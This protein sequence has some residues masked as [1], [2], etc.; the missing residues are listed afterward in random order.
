MARKQA[1]A[2]ERLYAVD[3]E[4][5]IAERKVLERELRDRGDTEAAAD[6]AGRRKPMLPVFAANRLARARAADVGKLIDAAQ[7]IAAA[8]E[9]GDRERLRE[10]QADLAERVRELLRHAEQ[11]AGRPL[12]DAAEQ[13]LASLLRA[14]AVDPDAAELLRRGVLAEELEPAG[15][16]ALAGLSLA[17]APKRAASSGQADARARRQ[18]ERDA[19]VAELER[20][21]ADARGALRDAEK[22]LTAAERQADRARRRVAELEERLKRDSR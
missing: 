17:P 15:F 2:L 16:E 13:R 19:K 4:D 7:R 5:F 6:V 18:A 8:H 22:E 3:P 10:A 12:S 9:S 1:D 11:A 21:L 20:D 14:A